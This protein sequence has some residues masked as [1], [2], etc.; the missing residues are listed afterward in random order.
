MK[1]SRRMRRMKRKDPV[2]WH[3]VRLQL[4]RA[5]IISSLQ[6]GIPWQQ[7]D[8]VVTDALEDWH[9]VVYLGAQGGFTN[10][11]EHRDREEEKAIEAQY[12]A[13]CREEEG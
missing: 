6:E 11:E 2:R 5:D 7:V 3:R 8:S 10:D 1:Q 9:T 4:L 13:E 12:K